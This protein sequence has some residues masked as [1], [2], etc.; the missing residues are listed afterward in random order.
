MVLI[1][2]L[3]LAEMPLICMM[4]IVI[5]KRCMYILSWVYIFNEFY[6][7]LLLGDKPL[8]LFEDRNLFYFI[9]VHVA[10]YPC[11]LDDIEVLY[12]FI[13]D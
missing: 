1:I 13:S 12:K 6:I 11:I 8:I 4:L 10:I 9:C 5:S 7:S 3:T 2:S